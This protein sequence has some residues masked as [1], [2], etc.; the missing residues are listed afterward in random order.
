[1]GNIEIKIE[2][3]INKH[4]REREFSGSD[5]YFEMLDELANKEE[6]IKD[7]VNFYQEISNEKNQ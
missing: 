7:L 6:L 1:M 4:T 3:I 2:E 5:F